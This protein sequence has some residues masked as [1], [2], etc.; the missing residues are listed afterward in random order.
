MICQKEETAGT[1]HKLVSRGERIN[2][3]KSATK[4]NIFLLWLFLYELSRRG[5]EQ[6]GK[7]FCCDTSESPLV[8]FHYSCESK[9]AGD[10]Y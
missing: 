9:G 4:N 8:D 10:G 5:N 3:F 1:K 6:L 2:Y 7:L